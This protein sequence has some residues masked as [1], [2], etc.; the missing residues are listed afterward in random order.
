MRSGVGKKGKKKKKTS[1]VLFSSQSRDQAR[2][3]AK[4][5]AGHRNYTRKTKLKAVGWWPKHCQLVV[6]PLKQSRERDKTNNG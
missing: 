6:F 5:P 2:Q 3:G 4:N 1:L